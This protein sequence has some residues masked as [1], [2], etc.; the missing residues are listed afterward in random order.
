[1]VSDNTGDTTDYS[2]FEI[3]VDLARRRTDAAGLAF[4]TTAELQPLVGLAGQKRADAAVRFG[5]A[6]KQP[7][8]HLFVLG[9]ESAGKMP[10]VRQYLEE[11]AA[12]EPAPSDWI[13]VN[14]FEA[15]H[16]PRA[17][18]LPAG[19]ARPFA[20]AIKE[21]LDELRA[22]M[23]AIF[24][25]EA[26][27]SRRSAIE[28]EAQSAQEQ[29]FKQLNEDAREH[30]IAILR[31]PVGFAMAPVRDGQVIKPEA[32]NELPKEEQEQIQQTIEAL[33]EKLQQILKNLPAIE[34]E[35]RRRVRALNEELA[36]VAVEGALDDVEAAFGDIEAI[37]ERI[38]ILKKELVANAMSFVADASE[39]DPTHNQPLESERDP[40]YRRYLVNPVVEGGDGDGAPVLE[41]DNPTMAN[42]V[43]RIE[44]IAQMG[45]LV[46]DFML[47]K[48][49]ALH[50]ANGGY[51][52]LDA[53][54]VLTQPFAWEA[55]KRAL[56]K[57][58]ITIESPAEQLSMVTTVTLQPDTIPLSIKC[59]LFGDRRLYYLL[60]EL[61]PE[62]SE[63]FKVAADFDDEADRDGDAGD[64]Y[65]RLAASIVQE[66]GLRAVTAAGVAR[67]I[68][69]GSR[70][71]ADASK[72]SLEVERLEEI[73]CEADH[74]ASEAGRQHME[75]EDIDRAVREAIYRQSR[76]RERTQE[77]IWR[78][79]IHVDTGGAV[80][81]QVNGLSVLTLR[82]ASFGRPSR[83]TARVRMGSGKIMDIEREVELGGPLHSKGVLILRG[84]LEGKYAQHVPLSLSASLVFEQSYGGVDGD[85]ASAAELVALMSAL[86][87]IP[88]RQSLAI[89]GSVDQN[90]RIQAIGGVNEKI[91]GFFDVCAKRGLTGEQGVVIPA[92][93]KAHLMLRED[94][95]AAIGEG[96]FHVYAVEDIDDAV[97]IL[98]GNAAGKR[99]E[100]GTYP[101]NTV[102]R[103]VDDRLVAFAEERTRFAKS[104]E[105]AARGS[106]DAG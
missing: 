87:G 54:K 37:R 48:P 29:D 40:R 8:F 58:E 26:Y 89:T 75:A 63:L 65:A 85:S 35:R 105:E 106:S 88:V 25:G 50:T 22:A 20:T 10:A 28:E 69:E 83:I 1:M 79:I 84:F 41:A 80:V 77:A 52:L 62:F 67:L 72:L 81:G 56:R 44:H 42:L 2:R 71:A 59:V 45:A 64:L 14:T 47:I 12:S 91:E 55:L 38:A 49:G 6:I 15:P 78:D 16:K 23:L 61:D 43:G 101:E 18:A 95:V 94:V 5:T 92:S 86:S 100:D 74:W 24:E 93:N 3:G 90:G 82:Q 73:L 34:K 102:N 9:P 70:L 96:K 19:R 4:E 36:A 51:L 32:F 98:T 99:G 60:N 53:R 57:Q 33:Q 66:R 21:A 11:R 27:Q 103:G 39:R 31:T 7:G 97:E 17:I 104:M 76:I 68:D 46:T 30:G 13:Y